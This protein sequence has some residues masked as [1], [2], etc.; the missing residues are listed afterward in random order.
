MQHPVGEGS[1]L[2]RKEGALGSNRTETGS[3]AVAGWAFLTVGCAISP[4]RA[5]VVV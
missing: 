5:T 2:N 1:P 3:E 4:Q